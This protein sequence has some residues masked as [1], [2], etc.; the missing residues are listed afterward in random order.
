MSPALTEAYQSADGGS[1]NG[2]SRDWKWD[3]DGELHGRYVETRLC[4]IKTGP[5]AGQEKLRFEF[6]AVADDESI[7]VWESAVLRS[8]LAEELRLRRKLD[9]TKGDFEPGEEMRIKPR[10]KVRN[11]AG[12]ATYLDFE[13]IIFEHA[14]PRPTTA[15][16]L[17][18]EAE[19]P[20]ESADDGI[21]F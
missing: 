7:G 12:D 20:T 15:D 3:S 4:R 14:A 5:S 10:G 17:G 11:A 21:P 2:Q 16:L 1:A 13:P 8:K 18:A 9:P 19:K 6:H